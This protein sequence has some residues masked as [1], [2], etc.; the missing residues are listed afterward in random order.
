MVRKALVAITIGTMVISTPALAQKKDKQLT[1][2]LTM[3]PEDFA[4]KVTVEGDELDPA[5][6][7]DTSQGF[8]WKGGLFAQSSADVFLRAFVVPNSQDALYQVYYQVTYRGS[9]WANI[10]SVSYLTSDGLKTADVRQLG[11]DVE[12]S[13][14]DCGYLEVVAFDIDRSDLVALAE[15]YTPQ[16]DNPMRIRFRTQRGSNFDTNIMP[17]EAAGLLQRIGQTR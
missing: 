16:T 4:K 8:Q 12:C 5:V 9:D 10:T 6:T 7:Y 13:S 1:K 14:S 2:L 3:T 17:A 15:T 11:H